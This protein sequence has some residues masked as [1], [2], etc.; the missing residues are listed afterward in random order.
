MDNSLE[1]NI[2]SQICFQDVQEK[3]MKEMKEI[4][5]EIDF[6][7]IIDDDLEKIRALM[8]VIALKFKVFIHLQ[9]SIAQE[10]FFTLKEWIVKGTKTF[11]QVFLV[12]SNPETFSPSE[13]NSTRD[14]KLLQIKTQFIPFAEEF[15]IKLFQI[16]ILNALKL[17]SKYLNLYNCIQHTNLMISSFQDKSFFSLQQVVDFLSTPVSYGTYCTGDITTSEAHVFVYSS[18]IGPIQIG[19]PPD[20]IKTSMKAQGTVPQ[21]FVLP[22]NLFLDGDNFGDVEFPIYFNYFMKKAFL[23]PEKK[24]ILVGDPEHLERI[25]IVFSESFHGPS[26]EYQYYDE[27]IASEKKAEGY[28]LNLPAE[29]LSIASCNAKGE[30]T[31]IT[32]LAN[33]IPFVNGIANIKQQSIQDPQSAIEITIQNC[34][35]LVRFFENGNQRAS[36]DTK[37]SMH[38]HHCRGVVEKSITQTFMPPT[39]GITFLGVSHGFDVKGNTTGFIIWINGQG[40]LVDPPA[41]TFSYLNAQGIKTSFVNRIILT[42]C[43]SDHDSG[44]IRIITSGEKITL[45]TTKTINSSYLRKMKAITGLQN[46]EEYYDF[47]PVCIGQISR[48]LGASFSFDYSF[49]TIPTI[50]FKVKYGNKMLSYSSD[51][52]YCPK[53]Y[54]ELLQKGVI[55]SAR[56]ADLRMWL[57]DADVIIHESGV[58]PI[59]TSIEV[60]ND[61]PEN[62]KQK[63]LIVHCSGIPETVEKTLLNGEK[64]KVSTKHL[65]Q[66]KTGLENTISLNVDPFIEGFASAGRRMKILSDIFLFRNLNPTALYELYLHCQE[67]YIHAE[68]KIISFGEESDYF[69]VIENGSVSV[70]EGTEISE[71]TL[72]VVLTRGDIFGENALRTMELPRTASVVAR[73]DCTL[74]KIH[75][76]EFHRIVGG[77]SDKKVQKD[78]SRMSKMRD[79]VSKVLAKT[80]LFQHLNPDQTNYV[81]SLLKSPVLFKKGEYVIHEGDL[82]KSLF[83]IQSGK[84]QV[85]RRVENEDIEIMQLCKGD[86]FGE[87]SLI[88]GLPRTASIVACEDCELLELTH[89][90]FKQLMK[91]YQNLRVKIAYLVEQRLQENEAVSTEL[92]SPRISSPPVEKPKKK[93]KKVKKSVNKS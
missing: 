49:H 3:L 62:I 66:P 34:D 79:F 2:T 32:D 30:V 23:N 35:G 17:P 48:I 18:G 56:E 84:I 11:P 9:D 70:H 74:L 26:K 57:F 68:E 36:V 5:W 87:L 64:I 10:M 8:A 93:T 82:D 83:I 44:T 75:S 54:S 13:K 58:P 89:R 72:K 60:L 20:T 90:A 6:N 86:V 46:L 27:E 88:T 53:T 21:I 4:K 67:I 1:K 69:Y 38:F 51:T 33:F 92:R 71:E 55:C 45:Y 14:S 80:Y 41:N 85:Q 78:I 47:I 65:K 37:P 28:F 76:K 77:K 16:P 52:F 63:M 19:I 7:R 81:A 12:G 73:T 43:H 22:P 59:H 15:M 39:F 50:R 42:H 24:I 61:L 91:Q 31:P 40:I 25:K 29:R